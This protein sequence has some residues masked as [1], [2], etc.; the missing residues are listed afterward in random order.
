MPLIILAIGIALLLLLML[1]FKLNGFIALVLVA[2]AVGF[3][4]GMPAFTTCSIA[5][6]SVDE[7]PE[8]HITPGVIDSMI[9]GVGGQTGKLILIL[10]FGAM[11]GVVMAEMGAAHRLAGTLINFAGIKRAQFAIVI[12]AFLIGVVLFWESAWVILIPIVFAIVKEHKLPLMW[13]AVPLAVALSTM[14]SFLPPHPGPTAVAGIYNA[15]IGLTLLYGL[16]ISIPIGTVVSLLWPR[17]PFVKKIKGE[18]P[19]GLATEHE[20]SEEEMPSFLV[21]FLIMALPVVLIAVSAICSLT[22]GEEHTVSKVFAVIGDAPIALLI[23]L[24]VAI[25]YFACIRKIP[26]ENLMKACSNAAQSISMIIFVIGGGGAFKEVLE[27]GGI[28]EFITHTTQS[29]SIPAIVLAWLIAALMRIALG[30]ASVAVVAAAGI[31]GGLVTGDVSPELMVLATA[32]GSI[33]ASHVNDPGFWMFKEFLGL[34]LRDVFL[35]RTTYTSV[36][37]VAGLAGCLLLSLVVPV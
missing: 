10:G 11:L 19:E 30:S 16:I 5:G 15:N 36:L 9:A 27:D 23:G 34:S 28:S 17:L 31:A 12:V 24:C 21:S 7:C 22:I 18:I 2:L 32:C 33:M 20:F 6:K 13:L 8:S 29:W 1:K 3:M 26:M 37:S 14:H 35:V 4:Q 25:L